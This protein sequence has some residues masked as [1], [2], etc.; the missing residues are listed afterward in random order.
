MKRIV[1]WVAISNPTYKGSNGL[2][3]MSEH[4]PVKQALKRL[5]IL[6]IQNI[7]C[8]L[9]L[10]YCLNPHPDTDRLGLYF[11]QHMN[12]AIIRTIKLDDSIGERRF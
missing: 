3:R 12:H 1:G 4:H 2:G 6:N 8:S 9:L 11:A 7:A 5:K 10:E